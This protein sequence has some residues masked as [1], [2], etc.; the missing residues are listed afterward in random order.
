LYTLV[1]FNTLPPGFSLRAPVLGDGRH[2]DE[3]SLASAGAAA[4]SAEP[5]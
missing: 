4:T 2:A 5:R 1:C 3:G